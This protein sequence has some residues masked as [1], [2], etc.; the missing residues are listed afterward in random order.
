M[1]IED[2]YA[3][4]LQQDMISVR[5]HTP[6]SRPPPG[7]SIKFPKGKKNGIA[8]KHLVR[9]TTQDVEQGLTKGPFV[10]PRLYDIT[11]DPEFVEAYMTKW[12]A[13]GYF[14][15]KPD[16][17][18]WS[19]FLIARTMKSE[20]LP[21]DGDGTLQDPLET[22]LDEAIM[23]DFGDADAAV[24]GS[25]STRP[26]AKSKRTPKNRL[27]ISRSASA[28]GSPAPNLFDEPVATGAEGNAVLPVDPDELPTLPLAR[29][30]SR[31]AKKGPAAEEEE[32]E[33]EPVRRPLRSRKI[34]R[35]EEEEEDEAVEVVPRRSGRHTTVVSVSASPSQKSNDSPPKSLPQNGRTRKIRTNT[36]ND[37]Q[38]QMNGNGNGTPAVTPTEVNDMDSI[39]ADD[40]AFAK[41]LAMEEDG[42]RRQLRSRSNTS[43]EVRTLAQIRP[44]Q[45]RG[46]IPPPLPTPPI[47]PPP[48]KRRRVDA[49]SPPPPTYS[50]IPPPPRRRAS[51]ATSTKLSES[52]TATPVATPIT[53]T[54]NGHQRRTTRSSMNG[55]AVVLD[56]PLSPGLH[57]TRSGALRRRVQSPVYKAEDDQA[58]RGGGGEGPDASHQQSSPD[59]AAVEDVKYEDMD[60]PLTGMSRQSAPSDDTVYVAEDHQRMK[61]AT[62]TSPVALEEVQTPAVIAAQSATVVVAGDEADAEGEDDDIDAEGEPD[63]GDLD[64]EGEPDL[65]DED[66]EGEVDDELEGEG[67]VA[68]ML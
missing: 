46:V 45:K 62:P 66:A 50:H 27:E 30:G 22:P 32:E 29:P 1:T 40:E 20:A 37:V 61:G 7:K 21:E 19:P 10:P 55:T 18:K 11:W 13:K 56:V 24:A 47:Q 6:P 2:I 26:K 43:Q 68:M 59:V 65:G 64:A 49:P 54:M 35:R 42:P 15:L 3:T 33:E 38:S 9:T 51:T 57:R 31:L 12:E 25:S 60:T 52:L 4:L 14:K 34:S 41:R 53:P 36:T 58:A 48:R 44:P 28:V 5:D 8:R 63:D 39:I 67:E 16:C 23:P 17:L